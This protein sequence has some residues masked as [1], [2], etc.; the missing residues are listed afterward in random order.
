MICVQCG[1]NHLWAKISAPETLWVWIPP[2]A[3]CQRTA[4]K[5]IFGI[6]PQKYDIFSKSMIS[7]LCNVMNR[8][9]ILQFI[10]CFFT[11]WVRKNWL[12]TNMTSQK[13][14]W[15]KAQNNVVKNI[16]YI[17]L[18]SIGDKW[19]RQRDFFKISSHP[20]FTMLLNG[21]VHIALDYCLVN[22]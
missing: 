16:S 19:L 18:L 14:S 6:P 17:F 2:I 13:R 22:T 7:F 3:M 5:N 9:I 15:K 8:A 21:T 20:Y 1:L 12:L 10:H 4:W 11:F